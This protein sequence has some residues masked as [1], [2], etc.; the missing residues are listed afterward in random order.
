M[1][2]KRFFAADMRQAIRQV[3][4]AQGPDA[5]I[6]SSRSVEGGIEIISAI[7]FD[8]DLVAEM[9][10]QPDMV[11]KQCAP[12]AR[13]AAA[14]SG[15]AVPDDRGEDEDAVASDLFG[16]AEVE[17]TPD[18]APQAGIVWAQDP[19]ISELQRELRQM[20]CL[21]QDQLSQL[22]W[23]DFSRREPLRAQLLGRLLKLGLAPTLARELAGKVNQF[24]EPDSAW[25]E[26]LL[27][28]VE[29][30]RVTGD[31]VLD[32]GGVVA[33]VGAT[34]VGKTTTVAKLAARYALR[35]GPRQV[36]LVTTDA[37]RVGAQKQLLTYGRILDAPVHVA[38]ND[39]ELIELVGSLASRGLVLIDTAGMSQ[40]DLR[41]SKQFS[42][43]SRIA[44]VR[45]YLVAS[46][47]TQRAVLDDV[48]RAFDRTRLAGCIVT[49]LDEAV[50]LG[51]V[52]SVAIRHDL[53]LAYMADGQQVPEDL[54]PA[55][56]HR[57]ISR[58]VA[59]ARRYDAD[60]ADISGRMYA[61]AR[62]HG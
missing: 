58:A 8:Q 10:A 23:N 61:E 46:A 12:S 21:L 20:K 42:R 9:A 7:D 52:L 49:K 3:R 57:L 55:R 28:L 32:H 27:M 53:P 44:D 36:A 34:G 31:E 6:L 17:S 15:D 45:S 22:A 50:S 40:R 41:L 60:D 39:Q 37:Y 4:E 47:N 13:A 11:R 14:V 43:L 62:K 25:R 2:I 35:H 1:K 16:G 59:M 54:H 29:S 18:P 24:D 5:V 19:A 51:G 38:A 26:A 56:A 30:L 33:L 48:V